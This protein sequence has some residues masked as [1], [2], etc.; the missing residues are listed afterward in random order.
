[1]ESDRGATRISCATELP[2]ANRIELR[3]DDGSVILSH[4]GPSPLRRIF[5]R[6]IGGTALVRCLVP[7]LEAFAA[8]A[9]GRP[10]TLLATAADG[11]AV[12][13]AID[14][15]RRSAGRGGNWCP[16]ETATTGV[17]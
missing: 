3:D 2:P 14:A 7:Q 4:A 10:Q 17:L 11:L 9:R 8:R 5:R 6:L 13:S 1:M 16:I 15:A 12:M